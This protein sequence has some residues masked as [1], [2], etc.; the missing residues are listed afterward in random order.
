MKKISLVIAILMTVSTCFYAQSIQNKEMDTFID[1]LIKKMTLQEKLGQMNVSSG[2]IQGVASGTVSDE[3][4]VRLG[5]IGATGGSNVKEIRKVQDIAVKESRLGIPLLIGIDVIHG[6][7]TIFPTPLALSCSWDIDLI[8]KTARV[9]A[10]EASANGVT[11]TYSPMVDIARDARWG[12][13]AEGSGEDPWWGSKVAQA[14]VRGYQGT[15]LSKE[16]TILSCFKHFALYGA[17]EAG[18]DY[19][20]V[21]MSRQQMYN[22]YLPP[23]K[24]AVDAGCATGMTSFNLVDGIPASGNRWLLT[25]LLRGEWGFKGFVVSDYTAIM[26]MSLHGM[27]DLE[28]VCAQALHAG[29]DMDMMTRGY[30]TV[31]EKLVEKGIVPLAEVDLAC[32]RILEAKYKL[33][34]FEDPYRYLNEE[35]AQKETFTDEHIQFSREVA[36]K[37]IVLLKNEKQLLPLKKS[38]TIAV[39]G[40]LADTKGDLFGTWCA[41]NTSKSATIYE[42]IK[43]AVGTKGNVIFAKGCNFTN[44]KML[45]GASGL[46]ANPEENTALIKEAIEKVQDADVIIAAMGERENWSGEACSLSDI[47]L[48]ESQRELLKALLA[49]QKPVVLVLSNGRPLVLS[50]ENENFSTIVEAWQGGTEAAR[51]LADVLF[52]EVNPSGKLT[53]TFPRNMG[54]IPIYYNAKPTGRPMNPKEH[55]TSKYLDIPNDPLF[56]FGYGLSYTTFSYGELKLDQSTVKGENVLTATIQIT[57]TGSYAGEEVVQLYINDPAAS[58]SRPMKELK[59]LAKVSL[60]PS[61]SK[62]VSFQIT[63]DDLKFYNSDLQHVWEPGVFNIYVGSNSRDVQSA[64]VNWVK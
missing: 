21:D 63:T 19:N 58:I 3:E 46:Q 29:T 56:P 64:Q 61:E 30:V 2:G 18:R 22:E 38:G 11:W 33:G 37:S 16:N 14:M 7:T 23:Y 39:V 15:D 51:A 5:Y 20:T 54:Q 31:I 55:F 45:A 36:G 41:K 62:V 49:T 8:E 50:W 17:A 44:N 4:A 48:Q 60:K 35:R 43:E 57:N 10:T 28:A 9:A 12:R 47:N 25:D 42:A 13:I 52:G 53:T 34:L 59:N 32:R 26:E 6:F 24:A 1:N 27:G 40:P